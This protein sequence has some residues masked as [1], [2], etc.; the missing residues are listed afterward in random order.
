MKLKNKLLSN[1][2]LVACVA[3]I[4]A[5]SK[6][7]QGGWTGAMNGT[8]Y[9]WAG[10]NVVSSVLTTNTLRTLNMTGPSAAMAPTTGYYTN[11]I[12]PLG[13]SPNTLARIKG[14]SGY[15]WQAS[16]SASN[17]DKTDNPELE[18]RVV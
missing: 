12:L 18:S 16:T 7:V 8:G 2:V 3:A 9:G 15:V 13:A 10:V 6:N 4:T 14:S 11:R 5:H 1:F 17:G